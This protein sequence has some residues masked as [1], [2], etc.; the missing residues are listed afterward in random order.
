MG[1]PSLN[2]LAGAT[3]AQL[4]GPNTQPVYLGDCIDLDDLEA[5][6][7]EIELT[8]CYSRGAGD[9]RVTGQKKSPPD[10][11]TTTITELTYEHASLLEEASIN[12]CPIPF[13]ITLASCGRSDVITN[14]ERG[15]AMYP[16]EI[17]S[18]TY[19]ALV[20][21]EEAADTMHA[22]PIQAW[23]PLMRF[24]PP[25]IGQQTIAEQEAANDIHFCND[26]SC[27]GACGPATRIC[28]TGIVVPDSAVAP[29]LATP[30]LTADGGVTWT[31]AATDPFGA[32]FHTISGKCFPF[33]RNAVRYLVANGTTQ[34]GNPAEVAYSDDGGATWTAV[35]AG[36]TNAL[37]FQRGTSLF[38][39][40][41]Y[42]IWGCTDSG[43]IHFSSD[44][45]VTWT[46]QG[47]GV[48]A[49]TLNAIRFLDANI[50]LCVGATNTILKTVDG[51]AAWT[52]LTGPAGQAAVN[53]LCCELTTEYRYF[54]GYDDGTLW[55]TEDGGTTWAQ[56]TTFAESG[57]GAVNDIKFVNELFGAMVVDN[58]GPVGSIHRTFDGGYTWEQI[59]NPSAPANTGLNAVFMCNENLIFAAGE[60]TAVPTAVV[61]KA[62]VSFK[63]ASP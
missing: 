11:I 39:I 50:G 26:P 49:T 33:G 34:A 51:G 57:L 36:A 45:G 18:D 15:F 2:S 3:F 20:T 61:Y 44:G 52:A 48:V 8:R 25:A 41:Q 42:H 5:P 55:Y 58:A 10:P 13:Y 62:S 40:D 16:A 7:G 24:W 12:N 4:D 19:S 37:F 17:T 47:A 1:E 63:A 60:P 30:Y 35:N 21:R 38:V 14:Y 32:G 31:A 46:T 56:R 9:F 27:G 28:T 54:I 59:A 6:K 22:V 43:G 23:P 29:A 53:I